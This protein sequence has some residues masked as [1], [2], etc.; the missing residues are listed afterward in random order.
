MQRYLSLVLV[1]VL[2]AFASLTYAQDTL[3]TSVDPEL[4]AIQ[5]ARVPKEYTIR[6]IRVTGITSLD[7]AIV[8]SGSG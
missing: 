2:S 7:T 4:L 3:V 6:N 1:S 8:L 5:N